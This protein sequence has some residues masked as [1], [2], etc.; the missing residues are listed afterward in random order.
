MLGSAL[1]LFREGLEGALIV[2]IVLSYLRKLGRRD[3]MRPVWWG[4]AAAVVLSVAVGAVLLAV[5]GGL[6]GDAEPISEAVIAFLAA[7]VLTW[8]IFWMRRQARAIRGELEAKVDAALAVGSVTAMVAVVFFGVAREGLET[9]LFFLAAAGGEAENGAGPGAALLGGALGLGVAVALGYALYRG[10]H[11]LNL[12]QVFTVSG[13][14]ILV[15]AAGLLA[16]GVAALQELGLGSLWSPVY[17]VSGIDALGEEA[18]VGGV[19]NGLLGWSP[20]PSIEMIAVWLVYLVGVGSIYL[21][22]LSP[23]SSRPATANAPAVS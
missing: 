20:D 7:G 23:L 12:R 1:I 8:M 6:E 19:L 4:V 17:D 22:G 3:A 5:V 18:F 10:S 21:R 11:W 14:L 2:A 16:S 13:G 9:S 15:F